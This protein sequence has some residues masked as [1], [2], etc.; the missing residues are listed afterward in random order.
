MTP[1]WGAAISI[2]LLCGLLMLR[3]PM[4]VSIAG[5]VF[6]NFYFSGAWALTLPQTMMSG[7]GRFVLI[8]LPLFVL[9]GG[10][11]NAGGISARLFEF[12]RSIVGSMR[13]GLAHVNV[14]TSMFFGGMIGSSTADL[15]G[16][17]SIVIPAM[18]AN[19]YP[20]DFSAALTASSSGIGPLIPPSSPMILYSAV[21]GVSLGALFLAGLIPG[22]LLGLS[23]MLIVAYLARKRGWLPYAVFS[24]DEV[25]KSGRR[26]L[27]P[28]GLP[29][30]IVGGLVVGVFTPSEAGAFAVVYALFLSMVVH[31]ALNFRELYRVLVNAVQLSG[32]L[33]IIVGL[34]FALGAGLTNAHVPD[35]LVEI[36]DVVV[37]VDSVYLRILALVLLAIL[38]GMI[39]DPLIPV[40]L[41]II[42]PTLIAYNIDLVH[43]GVLMVIAVVIGQVTPPMAIALIIAGRIANVDQMRVLRANMP[44]FWGIIIFMLIAIAV[45]GLATW[46]P[47]LLRN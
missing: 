11:M 6:L 45:P 24:L 40:L 34:S 26:A 43:F 12:A 3:V 47:D 28:F 8:A 37:V 31:R 44:F 15:A 7:L 35:F 42:L 9:A 41:P 1:L 17:G 33:L 30:I 27:L 18:K 21:T 39:L 2:L 36:I 13:G 19:K 32:E 25:W 5:A 10:L 29:V 38:A 4:L 23:Q 46:L 16:T 20:A 14:V 22:L